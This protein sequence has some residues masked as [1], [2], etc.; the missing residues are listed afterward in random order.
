MCFTSNGFLKDV[1]V[2]ENEDLAA[3]RLS[4]RDILPGTMP[5]RLQPGR[6][7]WSH[8][9]L[10]SVLR[11]ES[12]SARRVCKKPITGLFNRLNARLSAWS[13][14]R[15]KSVDHSSP[16]PIRTVIDSSAA[17]PSKKSP[18]PQKLSPSPLSTSG[19]SST[20]DEFALQP[21]KLRLR[22]DEMLNDAKSSQR[23]DLQRA[24]L[25]TRR[26][27]VISEQSILVC[28]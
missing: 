21:T 2:Y 26:S 25:Y 13:L 16:V 11:V 1:R 27:M 19:V 8:Y 18:S 20:M 23:K 24:T 10:L 5:A 17:S 9:P 28:M 22:L 15:G 7:L 3:V 12:C 4:E 6:R 14:R